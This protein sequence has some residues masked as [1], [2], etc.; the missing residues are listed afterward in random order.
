MGFVS[1]P[2][3]RGTLSGDTDMCLVRVLAGTGKTVLTLVTSVLT[4]SFFFLNTDRDTA[5][6][7]DPL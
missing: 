7:T 2:P 6:V 4:M 5:H 3:L 1:L